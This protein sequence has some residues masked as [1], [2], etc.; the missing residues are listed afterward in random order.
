[1]LATRQLAPAGF[2]VAPDVPAGRER[3]ASPQA[4]P[5]ATR[6]RSAQE[7]A[8]LTPSCGDDYAACWNSDIIRTAF[9][10]YFEERVLALG[11]GLFM[12]ALTLVQEL[13][14]G[15]VPPPTPS[16]L[17]QCG[18]GKTAITTPCFESP[19][20]RNGHGYPYV[21]CPAFRASGTPVHKLLFEVLTGQVTRGKEVHHH[22]ENK[23]C[24]RLDHLELLT[25]PEHRAIENRKRK[26]QKISESE[27]ARRRD[28]RFRRQGVRSYIDPTRIEPRRT[29]DGSAPMGVGHPVFTGGDTPGGA[30]SGG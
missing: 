1:M 2:G 8:S 30:A 20:G 25:K 19:R 17:C 16:G 26:G 23:R 5:H 27:R 4:S 29:H 9:E 21:E 10:P 12:A 28:A 15:D 24:S 13:E 18:C 11:E 22:C 3:V 14:V 7:P 6:G